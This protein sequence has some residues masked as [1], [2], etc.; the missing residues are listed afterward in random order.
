MQLVSPLGAVY[1]AGTLSGN[2]LA[3]TAGILTLKIL[4]RPEVYN[5]LE[6]RAALLE[7]GIVNMAAKDGMNIKVQ[8]VGSILTVF[9]SQEQV[10]NYKQ[11]RRVDTKLYTR[12]FQQMLSGG[13]YWPPSQFEAA[14]VSTAHTDEDI[15]TTLEAVAKALDSLVSVGR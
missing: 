11:A 7:K 13:I 1:Q 6:E 14:F 5:Q 12:F 15:Q 8:R 10:V 2:P 4:S 9:F 3:M